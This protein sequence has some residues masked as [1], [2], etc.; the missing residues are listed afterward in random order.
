VYVAAES[1]GKGIAEEMYGNSTAYAMTDGLASYLHTI[2]KDKHLYCWAH[3]LRY[4]YE[5]TIKLPITHPPCVI[6]DRLVKLYQKVRANPEWITEQKERV[7]REELDSILAIISEDETVNNI[8]YRVSMQ[9]EGLILALLVTEDATNNLAE[10]ELRNMA[11]KRNISN[12]S[13]TY[14]GMETTAVIGSVLQTLGRTNDAPFLP[15]LQM[16]LKEG[17]QEKYKQYIHTA[18]DDS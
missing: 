6:R 8:L 12:G 11:I 3:L 14:K 5:E 18:Y 17:L 7:L 13:N 10:R 1:R 2:P 4:C 16:Y 15:T 9:K